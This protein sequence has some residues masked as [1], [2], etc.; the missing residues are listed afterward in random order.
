M[1]LKIFFK[2]H[3][4]SVDYAIIN[5]FHCMAKMLKQSSKTTLH[6]K[7]R[8]KHLALRNKVFFTINNVALPTAVIVLSTY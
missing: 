2:N 8:K 5:N 1:S 7:I 3:I 6:L 4:I